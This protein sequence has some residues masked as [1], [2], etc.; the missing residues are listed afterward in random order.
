MRACEDDNNENLQKKRCGTGLQ[1]RLPL[2]SSLREMLFRLDRDQ[3]KK[4]AVRRHESE[5]LQKSITTLSEASLRHLLTT[6]PSHFTP[7]KVRGFVVRLIGNG[8]KLRMEF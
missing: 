7:R 1:V 3:E 4:Q 2:P 5:S 6:P 8:R